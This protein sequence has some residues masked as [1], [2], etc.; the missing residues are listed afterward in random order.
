MRAAIFALALAIP[1]PAIANPGY[2]ADGISLCVFDSTLEGCQ[3]MGTLPPDVMARLRAQTAQPA[4]PAQRVRIESGGDG[5]GR[6]G[7]IFSAPDP[8][9]VPTLNPT[10][11]P[12]PT[13][14]VTW[15]AGAPSIA[16]VP[17]S[18]GT[19]PN[20]TPINDQDVTPGQSVG[21]PDAVVTVPTVP[22]NDGRGG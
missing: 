5:E 22:L 11:T 20:P 18:V 4:A 19:S 6:R 9:I 17:R 1:V 12:A 14:V 2:T 8:V 16:V 15:P 7:A 3:G 21:N 10:P 13:P